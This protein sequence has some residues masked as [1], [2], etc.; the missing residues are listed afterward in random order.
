MVLKLSK[1]VLATI[2]VWEAVGYWNNYLHALFYLNDKHHYTLPLLLKD[3]IAG[4]ALA[5]TTGELTGSSTESVIAAT[6]VISVVPILCVYPFL[7]KHFVK[8]T[9]IGAVKS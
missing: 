7:Q 4:Q 9:L 3:I 5:Q 8:G 2:S 6:I 1:P